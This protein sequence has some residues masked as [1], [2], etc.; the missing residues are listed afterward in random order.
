[1]KNG[2]NGLEIVIVDN[3]LNDINGSNDDS[4]AFRRRKGN[5]NIEI[6]Q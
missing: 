6:L 5:P 4:V 3:V 1:M 2:V